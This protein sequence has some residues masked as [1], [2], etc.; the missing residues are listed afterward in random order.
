MK[1]LPNDMQP[2]KKFAIY[3][4]E[5]MTDAELLAII[6]KSGTKGVS[7]LELAGMVLN[8][9]PY[10]KGFTGIYHLGVG[11]LMK[12]PGIG[13]VKAMELKC[14]GE[15]S[16]RISQRGARKR[17][18]IDNP[19]SI[20]DYYM[21]SLSHQEQEHVYCMMLDI[22]NSLLADVSLTKGTVNASVVSA[23]EVFLKAFEYHAVSIILVHNHPSGDPTPSSED[24][25]LT[26]KIKKSGEILGIELL[27]HVIIGDMTYYSI[28]EHYNL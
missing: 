20:A 2:Y 28:A 3:G 14:L 18:K 26:Y 24:I 16:K 19:S 23:R 22:K 21:E 5:N 4:P 13:K 15:I 1:E 8:L 12:L 17:L 6:L 11:E 25:E 10:E 9:C 27:D 7:A